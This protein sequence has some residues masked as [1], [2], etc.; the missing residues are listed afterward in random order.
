MKIDRY[1][2]YKKS[3][4][5]IAESY[6]PINHKSNYA[7]IM[8]IMFILIIYSLFMTYK[9]IDEKNRKEKIKQAYDK[10]IKHTRR[11][12]KIYAYHNIEG[13]DY[14]TDRKSEKWIENCL[15]KSNLTLYN[16]ANPKDYM[17][18]VRN[19]ERCFIFG[20][21]SEY[22]YRVIDYYHLHQGIDIQFT[23]NF[24]AVCDKDGMVI[25]TDWDS[26]WGY[27]VI[28]QREFNGKDEI[29]LY[30]HL[31]SIEVKEYQEVKQG[32]LVGIVG[33]SGNYRK[34]FVVHLHYG[35]YRRMNFDG[36][37]Y[38]YNPVTN[39]R[40]GRR[41]ENIRDDDRILYNLFKNKLDQ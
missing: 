38:S 3:A 26:Y 2:Q 17:F 29:S 22:G 21:G 1:K 5:F 32:D 24:E 31:S 7:K 4:G 39:S 19:P 36:N 16:L 15:K 33:G 30:A 41:K 34:N 8:I 37:Y 25:L 6:K 20:Y 40:H 9:C 28:I 10:N 35:R 13:A 11:I 12:L 23:D 18:P 27:Y 14:L